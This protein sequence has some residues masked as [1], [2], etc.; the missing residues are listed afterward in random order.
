MATIPL[1]LS[2]KYVTSWGLKE[3]IREILQNAI[4]CEADGATVDV[5]YNNKTLTVSTIGTVLDKSTLLLGESGK[6][7]SRYIGKY[8]EGYKL[9]LLV[10]THLEKTVYVHTQHE[11]WFP[12][13]DVSEVFGEECLMIDVHPTDQ[14]DEIVAFEIHDISQRE[15][16]SFKKDFIALERF[17]GREVGATRESEYGTIMLNEEFKGRF[18][19]NGLFVQE[20]TKF[21]YG[22]DFKSEYVDLDRDRR[23]IN[24]YDLIELT[25]QALT[26]CGDVHILEKG[27]SDNIVDLRDPDKV[28]ETLS[29]EVSVNFKNHYFDKH[30]LPEGTLVGTEKVISV[31]G[32]PLVHEDNSIVA[33]IIAKADGKEDEYDALE[34]AVSDKDNREAA[35]ADFMNSTYKKLYVWMNNVPGLAKFRKEEFIKII[36]NDYRLRTLNFKL[37]KDD[38]DTILEEAEL[39]GGKDK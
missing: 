26:D 13:F 29:E 3:A 8:G 30:D 17:L 6:D 11:T 31:S 23:A 7:D 4:D 20:D 22:Y 28:L 21:T 12:R 14:D 35:I 16:L 15:M 5:S 34:E 37:I 25:S 10:L 32:E 27:L 38:I 18:Y 24:Y 36:N 19:V 39:L 9:A 33:K 2:P 1:S